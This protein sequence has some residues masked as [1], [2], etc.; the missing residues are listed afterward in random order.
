MTTRQYQDARKDSPTLIREKMVLEVVVQPDG[1]AGEIRIKR[2]LDPDEFGMNEHVVRNAKKWKF[3]AGTK[4]G[5]S[6]PVLMELTLEWCFGLTAGPETC[7]Q[8]AK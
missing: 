2:P 1:T 7:G 4:D 6:V 8:P 5:R 3:I